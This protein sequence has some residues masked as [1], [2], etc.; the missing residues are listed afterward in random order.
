MCGI[1][2]LNACICATP[3]LNTRESREKAALSRRALNHGHRAYLIRRLWLNPTCPIMLSVPPNMCVCH[4]A[5][6]PYSVFKR[7]KRVC[8]QSC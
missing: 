4:N 6:S 8:Q 5:G 2:F 7:L 3:S 1:L